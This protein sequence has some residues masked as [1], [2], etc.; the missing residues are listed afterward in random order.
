MRYAVISDVHGNFEALD[1]VLNSLKDE[2]FDAL[3]FLGDI[4]GY[5]PD[6]DKCIDILKTETNVL[7]AGNHD[8]ASIGLTD[9]VFFNPYARTAIEWTQKVLKERSRKLLKGLPIVRAMPEHNIYL[10]HSTPK[11]PEKWHYLVNTSDAYSNFHSFSEKI[12]LVGHSHV[13]VIFEEHPKGSVKTCN[14]KAKIKDANRYII[15]VGSVGQPRD[16]NPDAAYA[17]LYQDYVEIKRVSYDIL[18]TQ[19][20]MR[21]AGLPDYLIERLACGR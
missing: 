5:G 12:C 13:P 19:Q 7:L 11:E 9:T 10:V 4:V 18:L 14:K 15:N 8:R 21:E 3:L 6:P 20:K 17:L 16:G 1:A 2:S